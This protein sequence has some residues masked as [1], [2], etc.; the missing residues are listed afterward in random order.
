M[1][2]TAKLIWMDGRLIPWEGAQVHVMASTLHYGVGV[3]EGV[4]CYAQKSGPAAIFRLGDHTD[5]L[6]DSARCVGMTL[7]FD[8]HALAEACKQTVV[9]NGFGDCYLRP[10]AFH[11][12]G[13]P[14]LGASNPVRVAIVTFP[15]GAY[16][17]RE[18]LERGIRTTISSWV[19]QNLG[20]AM[21]RA[22]IA[23]QYVPSVLAKR[24][25][26]QNGFDE[27]IFCDADG[28]VC[29]GTGE[30]L[31]IV[32]DGVLKTAPTSAAI[33]AGITRD[34]AIALARQLGL[35]VR[36]E[37]FARDEL[38]LADEAFFTGTAAEITPI[39]EVDHRPIGAGQRGPITERL[40]SLFFRVVRGEEPAW[41]RWLAPVA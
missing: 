40:Q 27:A 4:R 21:L 37:P 39:R 23:G 22:K 7:P 9:Q 13:E 41:R 17:G 1:P 35:E 14:G 8:H 32:K 38:F 12:D 24:L 15:W 28:Y 11:G 25:A 19:R 3:F 5:R 18:G 10:V 33:L 20:S 29:E 30:N 34:S 26:K 6:L 16:L 36:E 2:P 31:F